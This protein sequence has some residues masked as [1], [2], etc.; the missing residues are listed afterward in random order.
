LG[1]SV[2]AATFLGGLA[3]SGLHDAPSVIV[4][5]ATLLWQWV[6]ECH[7][8]WP[9]FRV[10]VLHRSTAAGEGGASPER[11]LRVI[12]KACTARAAKT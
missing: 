9:P 10:G 5:P 11:T 3:Y 12:S 7:R 4:C 1:K 8:W 6:R 2:Q